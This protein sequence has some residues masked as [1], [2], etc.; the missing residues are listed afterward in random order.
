MKTV[1]DLP[2]DLLTLAQEE[3][4]LPFLSVVHDPANDKII[5]TVAASVAERLKADDL[6]L[7]GRPVEIHPTGTY[8]A[9]S[10]APQIR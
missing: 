5:G 6:Q 10:G 9:H 7:F 1:S 3:I 8:V 4:C 2:S